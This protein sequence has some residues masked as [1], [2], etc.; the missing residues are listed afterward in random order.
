MKIDQSVCRVLSDLWVESA[1]RGQTGCSG[2]A[3]KYC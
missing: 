3:H 1:V 2:T